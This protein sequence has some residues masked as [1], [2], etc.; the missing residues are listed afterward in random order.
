MH[1]WTSLSSTA[2][3]DI[4]FVLN[5]EDSR[6]DQ[7]PPNLTTISYSIDQ[8]F[9]VSKCLAV[10][11]SHF[12]S[13]HIEAIL[14]LCPVPEILKPSGPTSMAQGQLGQAKSPNHPVSSSTD[15]QLSPTLLFFIFIQAQESRAFPLVLRC[16]TNLLPSLRAPYASTRPITLA[17]AVRKSVSFPLPSWSFCHI[18]GKFQ[19]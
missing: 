15:A 12:P 9:D 1:D 5:V 13:F 19:K 8:T 17:T 11:P 6:P 4:R 10:V 18:G 7:D 14:T 2:L 3:E 16:P